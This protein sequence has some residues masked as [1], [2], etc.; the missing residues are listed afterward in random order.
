MNDVTPKVFCLTFGV[1]FNFGYLFLLHNS[2]FFCTK[3]K[4]QITSDITD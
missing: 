3:A 1:H 2:L 4:I